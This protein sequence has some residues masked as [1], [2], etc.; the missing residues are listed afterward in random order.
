MRLTSGKT[1]SHIDFTLVQ[2]STS[3]TQTAT[4]SYSTDGN[5]FTLISG[6]SLGTDYKIGSDLPSGTIA[7]RLTTTT[8]GKKVGVKNMDYTESEEPVLAKGFVLATNT[9]VLYDECKL[10]I[11]NASRTKTISSSQTQ[12]EYNRKA[13]D[14]QV[15]GDFIFPFDFKQTMAIVKV[16][17]NENGEYSFWFDNNTAGFIQPG[18]SQKDYLI[19]GTDTVWANVDINTGGIADVKF[20]GEYT[21]NKLAY[22]P[23]KSV[24]SCFENSPEEIRLFVY[25]E[26]EAIHPEVNGETVIGEYNLASG[27]TASL[28]FPAKDGYN[29][30]H[31]FIPSVLEG[32]APDFKKYDN[33]EIL[34]SEPGVLEYRVQDKEM[35][36]HGLFITSRTHFLVVNNGS[37]G[38]GEV[39]VDE[40]EAVYYNLQ[41][42]R[43]AK[44]ANGVFIRVAGGKATKV[45]R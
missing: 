23:V 26:P 33:K 8:S 7:V 30:Y 35:L 36:N 38:I 24:F 13:V 9:D 20:V 11:T 45:V 21:H 40:N 37:S 41:G 6:V 28:I 1:L 5:N 43:V 10:I 32:E 42:L 39:E 15:C 18:S 12:S 19:T 29:V 3:E 16:N 31:R 17:K 34:L 27:K 25:S 44:P 14:V 2:W 4:L 22:D